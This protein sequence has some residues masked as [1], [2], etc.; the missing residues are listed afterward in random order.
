MPERF[1]NIQALRAVASA[2][3]LVMHACNLAASF[4]G[5]AGLIA[6]ML[7][8]RHVGHS[9]VD[10]FFVISGFIMVMVSL[11]ALDTEASPLRAAARFLW[12]RA[13]RIYPLFWI[14]LVVLLAIPALPGSPH[15]WLG[16]ANPAKLLLLVVPDEHPVAWTLTFEIYFYGVVALIMLLGRPLFAPAFVVAAGLFS[17]LLA[18]KLLFGHLQ[19]VYLLDPIA[20][21][22]V[23]GAGVA[24]LFLSGVRAFSRTA[25]ATGVA[26]WIVA[27]ALL[28]EATLI[29]N[30]RFLTW[31]IPAGLVLYGFVTAEHARGLVLPR[32]LRRL[33]D[34]SYSLYMWH[35][36]VLILL[37]VL[38]TAAGWFGSRAGGAAF[39]VVGMGASLVVARL[40]FVLIETRTMRREPAALP[41]AA[42]LAARSLP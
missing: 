16:I 36:P 35:L 29:S 3:V 33:G 24:A 42:S 23:I 9:G 22:F 11:R 5:D 40:S 6:V 2:L 4:G 32:W 37:A 21:E 19:G 38:W 15:A 26:L 10:Q 13:L 30:T 34:S 28:P 27:S 17:L 1:R 18:V 20:L 41:D 25:I 14:T 39:V 31:G 12:H 7:L 8:V